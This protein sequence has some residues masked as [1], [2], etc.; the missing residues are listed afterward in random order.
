MNRILFKSCP[1]CRTGDMELQQD[2][3]YGG[4]YWGCIQCGYTVS[5]EQ[6][7]EYLR[8]KEK[9]MAARINY[10]ELHPETKAKIDERISTGLPPVPPKPPMIVNGKKCGLM[11]INHYYEV[12]T[13]AIIEDYHRLVAELG[14][15]KGDRA[16]RERWDMSYNKWERFRKKH[17]LP[18]VNVIAR[19]SA[20]VK[21]EPEI[22][23]SINQPAPE[24]ERTPAPVSPG[25]IAAQVEDNKGKPEAA[26]AVVDDDG[27]QPVYIR[28]YTLEFYDGLPDFPEFNNNW[29]ASVKEKWLEVYGNLA[30]KK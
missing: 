16:T 9:E 6:M 8:K 4:A 7:P 18:P 25:S 29:G 12:N 22:N 26:E 15:S 28:S 23:Q 27:L 24:N 14:P 1:H 30:G 5:K 13:P 19:D 2:E 20:P 10:D 11:A 3:A 21:T 17:G